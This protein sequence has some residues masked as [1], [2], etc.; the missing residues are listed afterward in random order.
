MG[1]V[2]SGVPSAD[3]V[4]YAIKMSYLR[5]LLENYELENALPTGTEVQQLKT[6]PEKINVL[7]NYVYLIECSD[8]AK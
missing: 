7:R 3:N 2:N 1:I 4:G 8:T 6:L 5:T